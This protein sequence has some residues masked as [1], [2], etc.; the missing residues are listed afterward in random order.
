[1]PRQFTTYYRRPGAEHITHRFIAGTLPQ[2]VAYYD[3]LIEA[4]MQYFIV[5]GDGETLRLLAERVIPELIP[6][7]AGEPAGEDET[8]S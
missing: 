3:A 1:M 5:S 6:I 4:G 7:G 8:R 2:L